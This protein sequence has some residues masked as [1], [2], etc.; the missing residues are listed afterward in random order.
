MLAQP[1]ERFERLVHLCNLR[2]NPSAEPVAHRE[3]CLQVHIA[4]NV[5]WAEQLA[6]SS[7]HLFAVSRSRQAFLQ[8]SR[9]LSRL[10]IQIRASDTGEGFD[11]PP[12]E[13]RGEDS[14]LFR[15]GS[16][17]LP[18]FMRWPPVTLLLVESLTRLVH[19][20]RRLFQQEFKPSHAF[21]HLSALILQLVQLR[22]KRCD[23]DLRRHDDGVARIVET[24]LQPVLAV[25]FDRL[26]Q[27]LDYRVLLVL[28]VDRL[29]MC[30]LGLLDFRLGYRHCSFCPLK[31]VLESRSQR[32]LPP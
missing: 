14:L 13:G 29:L 25:P 11:E 26:V 28:L 4:R 19:L 31:L 18:S 21:R 12:G 27:T 32:L 16:Q 15:R 5:L 6:H 10:L 20:L 2:G 30:R 7:G 23:T 9:V 3:P 17:T 24:Q 22:L 1:A 8:R